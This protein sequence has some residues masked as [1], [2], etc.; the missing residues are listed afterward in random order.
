MFTAENTAH[1]QKNQLG[2]VICQFRY[3]E[4]LTISAN[5]PVEF[6]EAIRAD[7]P[8]Y[9]KKLETPAGS[10]QKTEPTVNHQFASADGG[11]RVN[12]T[13]RFLSV[14]TGHYTDWD[15]FAG[16]LD[17]V[18]AAFIR[19]Y[20]PAYFERIGLRY[21]NFIS[22]RNLHLEGIPFS[23]LFQPCWLGPLAEAD[24]SEQAVSRCTVDTEMAVRG[25]CRIKIHA[26]PG[27]VRQN[28]SE[29]KEVKF[30]FD[31]DVFMPGQVPCNL[32]TGALQTLHG[33][34]VQIFFSAITDTLLEAML[35]G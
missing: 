14:Y 23:Q 35:R 7:Y 1:L 21:L 26:G 31:Q 15:D 16:R 29:D 13:G 4:L 32:S 17:A 6:Q 30:I 5:S 18:L 20:R 27:L 19:I 34:A 2:E 11:W 25:G 9:Q 10:T 24:V 8:Q 28:G 33:Q 22:R 3:P 12:L